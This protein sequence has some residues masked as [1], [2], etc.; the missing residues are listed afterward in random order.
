M[1]RKRRPSWISLDFSYEIHHFSEEVSKN[2]LK[3]VHVFGK[4]YGWSRD[5]T[6]A[7]P[8]RHRNALVNLIIEDNKNE[9]KAIEEAKNKSKGRRK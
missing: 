6:C 5:E 9:E 3:I 1:E 7:L 4:T 8:L 2:D